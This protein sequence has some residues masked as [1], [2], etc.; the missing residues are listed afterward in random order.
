MSTE[1]EASPK[2]GKGRDDVCWADV[3][4]AGLKMKK[5][6]TWSIQLLQ[7]DSEDLKATMS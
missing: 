4:L 6:I 5:K 1:G 7:M 2:R 3:N